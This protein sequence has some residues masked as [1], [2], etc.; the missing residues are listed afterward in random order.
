MNSCLD[1]PAHAGNVPSTLSSRDL[2]ITTSPIGTRICKD[3]MS[4]VLEGLTIDVC[5]TCGSHRSSN[6][7]PSVNDYEPKCFDHY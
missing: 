4:E 2:A 1:G 7:L 3:C 6:D 5:D